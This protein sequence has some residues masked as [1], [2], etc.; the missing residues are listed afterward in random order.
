MFVTYYCFIYRWWK[1]H[2]KRQFT[3]W[4]G[5]C[6]GAKWVMGLAGE[7]VWYSGPKHCHTQTGGFSCGIVL[8]LGCIFWN[9]SPMHACMHTLRCSC[10]LSPDYLY[11]ESFY[12]DSYII[13][14]QLADKWCWV[15]SSHYS[16]HRDSY[17]F[18]FFILKL[19][20]LPM[21]GND[22]CSYN[23]SMCLHFSFSYI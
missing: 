11:S 10:L 4:T 21:C 2:F 22:W 1:W 7:V 16:W 3:G 14:Q 12:L 5:L 19:K 13:S 8:Y 15:L 6:V 9:P 20:L 23:N 17:I 18:P